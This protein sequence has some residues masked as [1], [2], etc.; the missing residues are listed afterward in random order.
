MFFK[1][2]SKNSESEFH[3][4]GRHIKFI[5]YTVTYRYNPTSRVFP[6]YP[7]PPRH[8]SDGD[9]PQCRLPV[10]GLVLRWFSELPTILPRCPDAEPS[11]AH[12]RT[13]LTPIHP[14]C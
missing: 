4:L 10:Q 5:T 8:I 11:P 14:R 3:Q 1:V 6:I 13:Q 9:I 12:Q 7:P 2:L